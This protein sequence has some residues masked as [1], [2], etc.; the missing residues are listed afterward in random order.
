MRSGGWH[1]QHHPAQSADELVKLVH[2]NWYA[3][4]GLSLS[5]ETLYHQL[6]ECIG[7]IRRQSRNESIGVM[8]GGPFFLEHPELIQSVGA[9]ATAVNG[10][11]AVVQARSLVQRKR[12]DN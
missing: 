11:D 1:V 10:P 8:V 5:H 3:L 4:I 7:D 12:K 6:S 9:D 2:D